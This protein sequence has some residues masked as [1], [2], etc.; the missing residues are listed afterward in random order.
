ML[1]LFKDDNGEWLDNSSTKYDGFS[2]YCNGWQGHVVIVFSNNIKHFAFI[3]INQSATMYWADS[4]L[5]PKSSCSY[6]EFFDWMLAN[7]PAVAEWLIWNY[8]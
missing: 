1:D 6:P 7:N 3:D 2:V 4:A 8:Q 5:P